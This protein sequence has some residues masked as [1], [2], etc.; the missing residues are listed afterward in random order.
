MCFAGRPEK[1]KEREEIVVSYVTSILLYLSGN[2]NQETLLGNHIET[3]IILLQN[4]KQISS[5]CA[6]H[7]ENA[8]LFGNLIA[9]LYKSNSSNRHVVELMSYLVT[10]QD[11]IPNLNEAIQVFVKELPLLLLSEQV[12]NLHIKTIQSLLQRNDKT[13]ITTFCEVLPVLPEKLDQVLR[14]LSGS[15]KIEFNVLASQLLKTVAVIMYNSSISL[16]AKNQ[17]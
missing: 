3:D 13:F 15:K 11:S 10:Q 5:L 1:K 2:E 17:D 16:K 12:T 6:Q 9:V 4:L 8:K 14:V 7:P